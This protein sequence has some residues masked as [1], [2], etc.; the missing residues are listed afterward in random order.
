MR[1]LRLGLL[2]KAD[3]VEFHRMVDG[4]WTVSGKGEI[5]FNIYVIYNIYK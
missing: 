1:Y 3:V 5:G 4:A 2:G